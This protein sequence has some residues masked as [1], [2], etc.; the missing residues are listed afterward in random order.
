MTEQE[1]MVQKSK[2]VIILRAAKMLPFDR[3]ELEKLVREL[4][5][6]YDVDVHQFAA[7]P[8]QAFLNEI[9][10]ASIAF[11]FDRMVFEMDFLP[12]YTKYFTKKGDD[13][14]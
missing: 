14:P 11:D 12:R 7:A 6:M 3:R 5:R 13:R 1:L 4:T 8:K 10:R 2:D 9:L